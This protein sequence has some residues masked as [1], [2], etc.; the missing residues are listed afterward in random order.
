[1]DRRGIED[2]FGPLGPV[3]LRRMFGGH[4]IY[5]EGTIFAIEAQGEIWLKADGMT[6][7]GLAAMGSRPFT[8]EKST[9]RATAMSYWLLPAEAYDDEALLRRL[10][11]DALGAAARAANR[12]VRRP[13]SAT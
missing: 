12:T 2:L 1:M 8:Y 13:K 3:S 6:S 10:A 9:G 4:G 5:R 7:P 11:L